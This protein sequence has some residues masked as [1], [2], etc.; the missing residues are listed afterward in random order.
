[1]LS[2]FGADVPDY[3]DG[4]VLTVGDAGAK[5][6]SEPEQALAQVGGIHGR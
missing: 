4:K 3:M 5:V 1:V 6:P 2:M